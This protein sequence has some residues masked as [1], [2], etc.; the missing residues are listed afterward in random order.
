MAEHTVASV[1]ARL[2]VPCER[3]GECCRR[4]IAYAYPEDVEREPRIAQECKP[5][6]VGTAAPAW[7]LTPGCPFIDGNTCTIYATRPREC[8]EFAPGCAQCVACRTGA[9]IPDPEEA[10]SDG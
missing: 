9:P 7:L 4:L 5:L 3:C 6:N 10:E 8:R 1:S 2:V